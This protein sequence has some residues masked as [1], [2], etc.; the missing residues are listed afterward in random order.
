M[1]QEDKQAYI[2]R[3][4]RRLSEHGYDP[5]SLGWGGGRERQELRFSV[6]AESVLQPD[7]SVLDVG[8]GFC[9]LYGYLRCTEWG[10]DY[11]GVDINGE[12]LKVGREVYPGVQA[13]VID[14]LETPPN[15][16]FSW[17]FA[18]G[19]FNAKLNGDDNLRHIEQMLGRM[20]AL[21]EKGV[22]CDFMSTFV[23]S[24]HPCA[25]YMNPFDAVTIAKKLSWKVLLR[26]DYLPYEFMLFVFRDRRM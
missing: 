14:I 26:M 23:D 24:R 1:K 18:S 19:V 20:F 15:R 2:E 7:D 13:S 21:S 10:G 6:F 25:Y 11:L 8:C 9:D 17:T 22:A 12:L 16:T 3:Y 5:K 4:N